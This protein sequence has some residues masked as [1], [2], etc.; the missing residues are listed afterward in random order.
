LAAKLSIPTIDHY[1]PLMYSFGLADKTEPIQYLYEGFQNASISM[2][3]FQI[4]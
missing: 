4:G 2:R 1:L 3:C